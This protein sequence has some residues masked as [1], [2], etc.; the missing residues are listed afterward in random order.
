M[1][2]IDQSDLMQQHLYEPPQ[3]ASTSRQVQSINDEF[4][5]LTT[6]IPTGN[7][8]VDISLQ[9]D[10]STRKLSAEVEME[11]YI[12]DLKIYR[13]QDVCKMEKNT[14]YKKIHIKAVGTMDSSSHIKQRLDEVVKELM[15]DI[16]SRSDPV[17]PNYS[18]VH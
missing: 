17:L 13:S 14:W 12:Y 3:S 5:A 1:D 7:T 8:S 4:T 18:Y 10:T 16:N 15:L 9:M 11:E 6:A 2:S